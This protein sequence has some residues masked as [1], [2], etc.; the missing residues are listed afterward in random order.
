MSWFYNCFFVIPPRRSNFSIH[1]G[2]FFM[3]NF[4]WRG[5]TTLLILLFYRRTDSETIFFKKDVG[6]TFLWFLNF[7][8]CKQTRIKDTKI[9]L[10]IF[11]F[12]IIHIISTNYICRNNKSLIKYYFYFK[13]T[14]CSVYL[15]NP[16][17]KFFLQKL[18]TFLKSDC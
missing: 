9:Y 6:F 12:K 11:I 14:E 1:F 10:T 3:F 15:T 17:T 8:W 13:I 2:I 18:K 16:Q 5:E 4:D 7:K